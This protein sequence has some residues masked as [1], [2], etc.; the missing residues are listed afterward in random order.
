VQK[1]QIR[2][3]GAVAH[4]GLIGRWYEQAA[5]WVRDV[6]EMHAGRW[7]RTIGRDDLAPSIER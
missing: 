5:E 6:R 3:T 1:R 2:R 4:R 7:E